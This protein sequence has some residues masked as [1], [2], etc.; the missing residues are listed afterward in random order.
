[1]TAR[2]Q[3][4]SMAESMSGG[5]I[6]DENGVERVIQRA[7]GNPAGLGDNQ[8]V[9][10]QGAGVR[11]RVLGFILHPSAAVNVKFRS[12]ANDI[13]GLFTFGGAGFAVSGHMEHGWF[14]TNANEALNLNNSGAVACGVEVIWHQVA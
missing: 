1:M 8:L 6:V 10:A 14:Q 5:L 9:A 2:Q 11:I 3:R 13:S 4:E 7:F 12:A